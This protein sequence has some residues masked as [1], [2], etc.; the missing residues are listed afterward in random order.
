MDTF[1]PHIKQI[2]EDILKEKVVE[3]VID[4]EKVENIAKPT[5][6]RKRNYK[7]EAE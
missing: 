2:I 1:L 3:N 7:I 6:S 4:T 5:I